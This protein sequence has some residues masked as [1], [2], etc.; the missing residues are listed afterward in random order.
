MTKKQR[1]RY[2]KAQEKILAKLPVQI[3][4]H[5]QSKDLTLP[6]D[7]AIT[8]LKRRQ[9]VVKSKRTANRKGIREANFLKSM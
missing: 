7:D 9:E 8:S 1:A 5:E 4:L 3:P 2:D 6:G